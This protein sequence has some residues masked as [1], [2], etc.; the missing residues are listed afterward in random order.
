[1]LKIPFKLIFRIKV[2]SVGT[3]VRSVFRITNN[4]NEF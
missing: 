1:M 2:Y 4:I 3:A